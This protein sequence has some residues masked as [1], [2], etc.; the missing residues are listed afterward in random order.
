MKMT[1]ELSDERSAKLLELAEGTGEKGFSQLINE[2]VD[3]YLGRIEQDKDSR[4]RALATAG[5]LTSEEADELRQ[6][7]R[8]IREFWR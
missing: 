2:A 6:A 5:S 3:L 8:S 4:R 7:T 1:I